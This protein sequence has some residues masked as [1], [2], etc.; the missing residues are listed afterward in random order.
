[1]ITRRLEVR[2]PHLVRVLP[3]LDEGAVVPGRSFSVSLGLIEP[4]EPGISPACFP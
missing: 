4:V 1:M 3:Q 2:L